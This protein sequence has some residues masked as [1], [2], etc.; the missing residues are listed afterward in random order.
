MAEENQL[1]EISLGKILAE[2]RQNLRMEISEISSYLRIK[3]NDILAIEN[4]EIGAIAKGLYVQGLITSYAKFLKIDQ[5]IIEE[6]IKFLPI[7][8]NVEN[9]KHLLLNIGE[10]TE[11]TPS[12]DIFFNFLLISILLFLVL[13][14][15]FNSLGDKSGLITNQN[16]ILE[17]G[18]SGF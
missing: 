4:D 2:K 17:L 16:L 12:K 11:L 1:T 3:P 5:K 8:S 7:K 13:L 14:S 6:K 10:N 18:G 15:I 9:K